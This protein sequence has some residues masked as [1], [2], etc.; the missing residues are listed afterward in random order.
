MADFQWPWQYN[1]PPF[2]TF[3]PN[4]NTRKKQVD[5]WRSL[6][7]SYHKFYKQYVLDTTEAQNSPLFYNVELNKSI[8]KLPV[9]VIQ[10][11]LEDLRQKGDCEWID[12]QKKR[13]YVYWRTPSE[14]GKQIYDWV[15]ANGMT[16]TV[17]T[18]YELCN[19]DDTQGEEFH[20]INSSVLMKALKILEAERKAEI[21]SFDGNE[22]VKFF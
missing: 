19:G 21:M 18:L 15:S 10:I 11:I 1:F 12:K 3:Q 16:G 22:G 6:I 4:L 9:D 14:W 20:G 2:F 7:L 5:A 17:C 8:G 13:C